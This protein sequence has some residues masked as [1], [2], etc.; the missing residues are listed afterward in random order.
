MSAD[1]VAGDV[2]AE[3]R[4]AVGEEGCAP[5]APEEGS[6]ASDAAEG[7]GDDG[8]ADQDAEHQDDGGAGEEGVGDEGDKEEGAAD[9]GANE[10]AD[11]EEQ[12][13]FEYD[14][15]GERIP[16]PPKPEP[17]KPAAK[18]ERH[19]PHLPHLP[20]PFGHRRRGGPRKPCKQRA[21]EA[22]GLRVLRTKLWCRR[23]KAKSAK[24][25]HDC[26]SDAVKL[27]FFSHPLW[28]MLWVVTYVCWLWWMPTYLEETGNLPNRTV[29][30]MVH[31][32]P[33]LIMIAQYTKAVDPLTNATS[34]S[35]AQ[36]YR[37]AA[38]RP[39]APAVLE[40]LPEPPAKQ[41]VLKLTAALA[42][43]LLIPAF[44]AMMIQKEADS[45]LWYDQ[46]RIYAVRRHWNWP[47][48]L[49]VQAAPADAADV[50]ALLP[51]V[52][53][54]RFAHL[55]QWMVIGA[56]MYAFLL[57]SL[58]L[59]TAAGVEIPPIVTLILAGA[60][61]FG[62]VAL[63]LVHFLL[64]PCDCQKRR[65]A[66]KEHHAKQKEKQ[67][68]AQA[69]HSHAVQLRLRKDAERKAANVR[70]H[71]MPPLPE[72]P[73]S[74]EEKQRRRA[75]QKA[76]DVAISI[77]AAPLE[78]KAEAAVAA[79][80]ESDAV[81]ALAAGEAGPQVDHDGAGG[82]DGGSAPELANVTHVDM[83]ERQRRKLAK[84][85]MRSPLLPPLPGQEPVAAP[86]NP[87]QLAI[88]AGA[89]AGEAA[90]AAA[91]A[92]AAAPAE[93]AGA[94]GG[95][96]A[97]GEPGAKTSTA[98]TL[99]PVKQKG[100]KE[101][102]PVPLAPLKKRKV[103]PH[104]TSSRV[105][106]A[107]ACAA[108]LT[109]GGG[110]SV[111]YF[112]ISGQGTDGEVAT[113][114]GLGLVLAL[115]V[116]GSAALVFGATIKNNL[117]WLDV[118]PFGMDGDHPTGPL[119]RSRKRRQ[120]LQL[121]RHTHMGWVKCKAYFQAF[122]LQLFAMVLVIAFALALLMA[123]ADAGTFSAAFGVFYVL[124]GAGGAVAM[125]AQPMVGG[126]G[127]G[128]GVA[129]AMGFG[130][131]GERLDGVVFHSFQDCFVPIYAGSFLLLA[132]LYKLPKLMKVGGPGDFDKF[133]DA[134]TVDG[135]VM[136]TAV[137]A[138]EGSYW[139]HSRRK[140]V[141]PA[142]EAA[143]KVKAREEARRKG[144]KVR[145]EQGLGLGTVRQAKA[146][147]AGKAGFRAAALK[148]KN[149]QRLAL[150][151]KAAGAGRVRSYSRAGAAGGRSGKVHVAE[152]EEPSGDGMVLSEVPEDEQA[153]EAGEV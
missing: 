72:L 19:A 124:L 140:L 98:V 58:A 47:F 114:S 15:D 120:K 1:P 31:Y 32:R 18:K 23:T 71:K 52:L 135:H 108:L 53:R 89:A 101:G 85:G 11:E 139:D 116:F 63:P 102:A 117:E 130:R 40:R 150:A 153:I 113:P 81:V 50:H 126:L 69:E 96:A 123:A 95:S 7:P 20:G 94:P 79:P 38:A 144:K 54:H 43:G 141:D 142:Q 83:H 46:L 5:G 33:P 119:E 41:F 36:E 22:V 56:G 37:I 109:L 133:R 107:C 82:E 111:G 105:S 104:A 121:P 10:D 115:V 103:P 65:I 70:L 67:T 147:P 48:W 100:D 143:E 91:A 4:D 97:N 131:L 152:S 134:V 68:R 16:K 24:T 64:T 128:I 59:R 75:D 29:V 125:L 39:F 2:L 61:L 9:E 137:H 88:A 84:G 49:S 92:A 60:S 151:A 74:D 146:P 136:G 118:E 129:F 34:I 8:D 149:A 27:R 80:G 132:T 87:T 76:A 127:V 3:A 112:D 106:R 28:D 17:P 62:A 99:P 45:S 122:T 42:S 66:S 93:A 51:F 57:A 44:A 110:F 13:D 73:L 55:S 6:A 30:P 21:K 86:G 78:A 90:P 148:V 26:T 25:W 12:S 138:P 35:F 14:S 145:K 77:G